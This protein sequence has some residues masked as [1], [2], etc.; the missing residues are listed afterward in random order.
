M[1]RRWPSEAGAARWWGEAGGPL[2]RMECTSAPCPLAC[3]TL[4]SR[5]VLIKFLR[6]ILS[7]KKKRKMRK[8]SLKV[9]M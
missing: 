8:M 3:R 6:S 7:E 4:V 2:Q 9:F 5:K 1:V